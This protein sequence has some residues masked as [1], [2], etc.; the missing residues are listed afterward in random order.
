MKKFILL[1]I[2]T[3]CM[4]LSFESPKSNAFTICD[5]NNVCI[6]PYEPVIVI[7]DNFPNFLFTGLPE[8]N[9]EDYA[10]AHDGF[11]DLTSQIIVTE[12][13]NMNQSGYY[14]VTYKVTNPQGNTTT[15]SKQVNVYMCVGY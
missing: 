2:L 15:K 9:W 13:V 5:D 7:S 10:T 4:F 8:P 6:D 14:T 12:D 1:V 11:Q 3:V